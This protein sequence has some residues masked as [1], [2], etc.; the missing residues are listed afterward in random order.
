[1]KA[2]QVIKYVRFFTAVALLLG[3]FCDMTVAQ[4]YPP[5]IRKIIDRGK[6]IVAVYHNDM[7]PFFMRDS[8]GGLYGVDIRLTEEIAAKL[9]VKVEF[10]CH[11]R[12][13]T[14]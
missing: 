12:R 6:L 13:S 7:A 14:K 5:D 2:R 8:Q 11:P 1:M 3:A 10:N 9:G 4:D